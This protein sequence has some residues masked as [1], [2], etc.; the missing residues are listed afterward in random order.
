MQSKYE[1]KIYLEIEKTTM[2]KYICYMPG[3]KERKEERERQE[4]KHI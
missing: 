1:M 2:L 4:L 3:E